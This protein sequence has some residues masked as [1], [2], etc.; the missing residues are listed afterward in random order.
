MGIYRFHKV[1]QG[2]YYT[3]TDWNFYRVLPQNQKE[4]F[5]ASG[6]HISDIYVCRQSRCA[7]GIP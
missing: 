5:A 6:Y 1:P 4:V 2:M 7:P 3:L